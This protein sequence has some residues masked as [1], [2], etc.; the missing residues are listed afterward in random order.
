MMKYTGH[1]LCS[2]CALAYAVE[3]ALSIL[4]LNIKLSLFLLLLVTPI[5]IF[6]SFYIFIYQGLD[7]VWECP[8]SN[9]RKCHAVVKD[10]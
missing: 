3:F 10:P 2:R 4:F 1:W 9:W 7:D 8:L 5:F 6:C